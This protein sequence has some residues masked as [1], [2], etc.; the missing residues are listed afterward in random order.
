MASTAEPPT[1][2][3][4]LGARLLE[5][6][7]GRPRGVVGRVGGWLMARGNADTERHL[8]EIAELAEQDAVLV[9][10]FGPGIGLREAGERC[11]HVTGIDPSALMVTTAH[12]RCADLI[13]QGRVAITFGTAEDTG[14]AEVAVSVVLSV[15]NVALWTDWG[16]GLRELHR[17]LRPGGRLLLSAH[18]KWLPGGASALV[19]AVE[20]AGYQDVQSWTWDPPGRGATRA[21]Q[22]RAYRR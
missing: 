8:V 19:S 1:E 20:R 9:V 13:S 6:G 2:G 16:C 12:R 7:F 18:Q 14:L 4:G 21:V 5:V 22:L 3:T 10:G 17:V 15:N 11:R